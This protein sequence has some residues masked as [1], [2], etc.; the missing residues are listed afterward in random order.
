MEDWI[1][2]PDVHGRDFWRSAVRGR[3]EEKTFSWATMWIR[4]HGRAYFQYGWPGHCRAPRPVP[5]LCQGI[6]AGFR[7]I[8]GEIAAIPAMGTFPY[9]CLK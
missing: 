6:Q 3:E 8:A 2:I 9:I 4:I 7:N 5:G 1:V